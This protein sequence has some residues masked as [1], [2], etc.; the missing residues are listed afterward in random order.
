MSDIFRIKSLCS[1]LKNEKQIEL[2]LAEDRSA[3]YEKLQSDL[4]KL[5]SL[6]T[7]INTLKNIFSMFLKILATEDNAFK[8]K[9]L[10]YLEAYIDRNLEIIFPNEGFKSKIYFDYSYNK[11]KV[12]LYLIDRYGKVR[13]P[14]VCEGSL[15]QQLIGFSAA[16]GIVE[17]LGANKLFMDEAFS[18]SSMENLTKISA[19][20]KKLIEED[21]QILIIEQKNDIFKD[22][23]RREINIA[24]DAIKESVQVLSITDY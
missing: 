12:A 6:N 15:L 18:A 7:D 9:R 21:F 1:S 19:L 8:K 10:R 22:L 11:Q 2:R 4:E 20:L 13:I 23:T 16:V 14:S 17:C 24:K 5:Q 3:K